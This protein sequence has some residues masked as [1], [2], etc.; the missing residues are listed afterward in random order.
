MRDQAQMALQDEML[1]LE[2]D[3]QHSAKGHYAASEIWGVAHY[4][5]GLPATVL[6]AVAGH[7]ALN[8]NEQL[9]GSIALLAAAITAVLTFLDPASKRQSHLSSANQYN[10]LE[11]ACRLIRT[12]KSLTQGHSGC[13]SEFEKL[14]EERKHLN[15]SSPH[16]P[17]VAYVIGKRRITKG[18]T[19]YRVDDVG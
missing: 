1:R 11:K 13:L 10:T 19:K 3:C 8:S 4:I 18:Q 5:V 9:A 16:I 14:A 7:Q 12:V 15:L 6:A 17:S 2:E